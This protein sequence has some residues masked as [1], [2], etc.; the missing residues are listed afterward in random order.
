MKQIEIKDDL[1]ILAD[2]MYEIIL[3]AEV[4]VWIDVATD[5][6]RDV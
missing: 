1:Q 3:K 4:Q 6:L 5:L 2:F